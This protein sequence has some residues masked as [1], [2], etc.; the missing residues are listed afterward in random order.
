MTRGDTVRSEGSD[1]SRDLTI[2]DP[3]RSHAFDQLS[4]HRRPGRTPN[5]LSLSYPGNRTKRADQ[6]ALAQL[7]PKLATT[8][9]TL[10]YLT[11]P[12]ETQ[13]LVERWSVHTQFFTVPRD[14]LGLQRRP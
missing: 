2:V 8:V 1:R 11:D 5:G 7:G 10:C 9:Q 12:V 6:Q 13:T 4:G 14:Y 3:G